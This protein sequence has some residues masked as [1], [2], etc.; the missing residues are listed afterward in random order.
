MAEGGTRAGRGPGPW[1]KGAGRVAGRRVRGAA[2]ALTA[3]AVLAGPAATTAAAD[4]SRD[5]AGARPAGG[6]IPSHFVGYSI[7]W[8]LVERYMNPAARPAFVNLLRNLGSGILRIGGGSQ[9][10]MP[11]DPAAENT[12]QI[13]TPDDLQAIRAT[14]DEAN[15]GADDGGVPSWGTSLG[16]AMAPPDADRPWISPEHA[17][18]FTQLGVVPAFAGAEREVVGIGLGNEPDISYAYDA[19]R[20]LADLETYSKAGVTRPFPAIAPSTSEPIAPWS[21]IEARTVPTRLFWA[22]PEILDAM[23]AEPGFAPV[24]T[25]HFYPLVRECTTDPY[26][27]PSIERLLS[28][29]RLQNLAYQVFTH[30]GE[31]ARHGLGYRL[32]EMNSSAHRGAN[33]VS[34]V[35]ASAVWG[36]AA[37]FEAACPQPPNAPGANADCALGSAGLSFHNAEVN[38]F[39]QPEEGN[40]YYNAIDY[41]PSPAAGPPTAAPLYYAQLLFARFAQGTR[42]LR[43]VAV[44]A[45][46]DVG[47]QVKAWQVD[48]GKSTRRL[49]VVNLATSPLTVSLPASGRRYQLD[50]MA[51]YDASGAGRTLDAPEVRIDGRAVSADGTWPGFAPTDGRIAADS[52]QLTLGVGEVAVVTL[53]RR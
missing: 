9:D 1:R 14:L 11:F 8:S 12:I 18:A 41:D 52:L 38:A 53:R 46:P 36:V 44:A 4:A 3:L 26:R 48:A 13:I 15:A 2:A 10:H 20:Y 51:P 23:L 25:D 17:R 43:P 42:G 47:A 50:R 5:L 27:C 49:F 30:A 19:A 35:A 45:D 16:T 29:E 7:E 37:M 33:G 39:F 31:A 22:W 32:Q 28:D 6:V 34:N 21:A 24:A 40:A